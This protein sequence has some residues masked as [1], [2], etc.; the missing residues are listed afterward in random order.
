MERDGS[1]EAPVYSK[2]QQTGFKTNL[3]KGVFR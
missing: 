1:P 3:F 2:Q